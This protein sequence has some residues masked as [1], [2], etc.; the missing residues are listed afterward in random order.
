MLFFALSNQSNKEVCIYLDSNKML[1]REG[2]S[3][4][5]TKNGIGIDDYWRDEEDP[6]TKWPNHLLQDEISE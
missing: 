1:K 6:A 3:R 2:T 5:I 4:V